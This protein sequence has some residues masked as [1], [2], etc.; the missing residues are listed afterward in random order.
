MRMTIALLALAL[1]AF[2]QGPGG[3]GRGPGG[4]R[5][6][7]DAQGPGGPGP[8]F[9]GAEA[10]MPGRT[11][12]GAPYSADVVTE[13][14]HTLADGNHIKQSANSKF[15]RDSEGRTRREQAVN[16]SGLAQ[17]ANMPNVV[18][19]HDPVAGAEYALNAKDRT[20]TKSSFTVRDPSGHSQ[21]PG[22]GP[23]PSASAAT[24]A[25]LPP[26]G[27]G[28]RNDQNIK[29]EALGKQMIEGVQAEGRRT[30]LTIPAG[31]V[32]N[33]QPILI[34]TE[35]WYSSELQTMV[36]SK[37]SDPRNGDTVTKLMNISR[38]EPSRM[39]FEAPA[40]YK[41]TESQRGGP[42]LHGGGP[43]QDK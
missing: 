17:S 33:E 42:R 30:T 25:T 26:H 6:F 14:S 22:R 28:P 9:L 31:K 43:A 18:F 38:S 1:S 20:G 29:E 3:P 5:G 35:T 24:G 19:I 16:L 11:V 4:R 27:R 8:R 2:A 32:G 7:D 41:V 10:G 13:T 12:K 39:L 15:Y 36:L 21:G 23:R 40:D 34:V 37:H